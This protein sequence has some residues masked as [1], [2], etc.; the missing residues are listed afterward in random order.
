MFSTCQKRQS[1]RLYLLRNMRI[2]RENKKTRPNN[3]IALFCVA[4]SNNNNEFVK[5]NRK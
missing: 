4:T 3:V 1:F 2:T 5:L